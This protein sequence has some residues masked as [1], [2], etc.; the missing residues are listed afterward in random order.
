MEN[1]SKIAKYQQIIST[2]LPADEDVFKSELVNGRYVIPWGGQRPSLVSAL[3]WSLFERSERGIGRKM[4]NF[5]RNNTEHYLAPSQDLKAA[6][7]EK[8][9]DETSFI[10]LHHGQTKV[11]TTSDQN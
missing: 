9:L 3:R 8:E 4:R 11:I 5:F 2:T 7:Q 6:L 10:T 1:R